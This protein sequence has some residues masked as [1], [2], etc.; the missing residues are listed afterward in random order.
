MKHPALLLAL[1][2]TTT[3]HA[4]QIGSG[5]PVYLLSPLVCQ[6]EK[7]FEQEQQTVIKGKKPILDISLQYFCGHDAPEKMSS[8]EKARARAACRKPLHENLEKTFAGLSRE[9]ME[10]KLKQLLT[11]KI[12]FSVSDIHELA[13]QTVDRITDALLD[14]KKKVVVEEKRKEGTSFTLSLKNVRFTSIVKRFDLIPVNSEEGRKLNQRWERKVQFEGVEYF[15]TSYGQ[16]DCDFPLGNLKHIQAAKNLFS[17]AVEVL[18]NDYNVIGPSQGNSRLNTGEE[19]I[20]YS[21][22]FLAVRRANG[23]TTGVIQVM[24]APKRDKA[25]NVKDASGRIE[26]VR[27]WIVPSDGQPLEVDLLT[28][29][30]VKWGRGGNIKDKG[31]I[32]N[33]KTS[34]KYVMKASCVPQALPPLP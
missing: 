23:E 22:R 15:E 21:M 28:L 5:D 1:L 30:E 17:D 25:E 34:G 13:S 3:A 12:D 2:T 27:Q 11:A 6:M 32:Q 10:E 26:L 9:E 24:R 31:I 4:R 8:K 16:C 33:Q 20:D 18:A 19:K 29:P 7:Q 14:P